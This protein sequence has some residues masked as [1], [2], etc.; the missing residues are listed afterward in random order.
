[1]TLRRNCRRSKNGQQQ[2]LDKDGPKDAAADDK[3][4]KGEA[5]EDDDDYYDEEV[6]RDNELPD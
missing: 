2:D 1:M 3:K 6:P 5:D 4:D